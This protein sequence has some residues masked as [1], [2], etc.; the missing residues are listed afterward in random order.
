MI[1]NPTYREIFLN[2]LA[3]MLNTAF[4]PSYMIGLID[5]IDAAI[6][7]EMPRDIDRWDDNWETISGKNRTY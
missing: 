6:N 7:P 5:S 2:R 1:Q 4:E 3:D